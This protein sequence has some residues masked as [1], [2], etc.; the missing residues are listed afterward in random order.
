MYLRTTKRVAPDGSKVEYYYLAHNFRDPTS[1]SPKA[2]I[3]HSFGRADQV[4]RAELVRLCESIARV[5]GV[6]VRDPFGRRGAPDDEESLQRGILPEGVSRIGTRPL[7]AVWAI[8]ALWE[9][10]EIGETLR[11]IER[12]KK[13]TVPYERALLAMTANRLCEPESKLGVWDR[14]LTKVHLPSCEGLK[15]A[16]MY[17]A[18]DLLHEHAAKVEEAVFFKTADLFN[19]E[20]DIIFYDTTTCQFSVDFA[21]EEED[22]PRQFGRPKDGGWAPQ[23]MVALAVTREGVPVR[24]WVFPGN[25]ADVTTVERV[26]RDLRGWKLGR[27]LFVGDGGMDSLANR[28]ELLKGCGRYLLAVRAG[29]V[30]EVQ[31]QVLSRAG[32]YKEVAENLQAK[33]VVVGTGVKRRRY[34]LC[35][36]PKEAERQSE[37]RA[38]VLAQLEAELAEH[39]DH[40][41]KQKW[42]IELMASGRFGR[43]LEVGRGGKVVIDRDAVKKAERMDGKWVLITNDDTLT[44]E[45]AATGYKSLLVIER[46]FR[47]L[48]RTQIKMSPMYHWLPRR[49]EAHVKICVLAL[50]LERVAELRVGRPWPVIRRALDQ[51]QVTEY[52]TGKH[53]FFE[54]N[55]VP[56]EAGQFL[57]RLDIS[58]PKS[59]LDI[60]DTP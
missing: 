44:V 45:D 13:G 12:A 18:M 11:A 31:K 3:V 36:N 38:A 9:R 49:I 34:I 26:K 10:L 58:L 14:W 60:K 15:L 43:Y 35:F 57:K 56:A 27:A 29:S 54:R 19:L 48:K 1:G 22:G 21:D 23:V 51:L 53:R 4:D 28:K 55:E 42:A 52:A 24:S 7:G 37:H 32:R 20:V 30:S 5:C 59:V 17:E 6:E 8:E 41:A 39:P 50:L 33:E 46:C 40:D 47:M 16:Q 2:E 25:T